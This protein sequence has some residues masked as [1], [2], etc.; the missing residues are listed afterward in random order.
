MMIMGNQGR[1]GLGWPS[2]RIN[3]NSPTIRF[4]IEGG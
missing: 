2:R 3:M 1:V 4:K